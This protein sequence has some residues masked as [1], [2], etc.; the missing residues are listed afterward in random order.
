MNKYLV[1]FLG[2]LFLMFVILT[3]G[4]ALPIGLALAIAIMFGG[5]ISGGHFNPAVSLAMF[6]GKRMKERDLMMY[7]ISQVLGAISALY[8]V[9]YV[10]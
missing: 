10:N 7:V 8:V 4:E 6:M 2:T 5:K 1:E 9:K 3:L